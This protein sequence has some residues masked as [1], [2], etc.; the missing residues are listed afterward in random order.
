MG[1]TPREE[2][3]HS[4]WWHNVKDVFLPHSHEGM[5]RTDPAME[6]S[7]RGMRA[8]WA[9]MVLLAV[10]TLV[11]LAVYLVSGSVAL[12]GDTL[13]N[14]ADTLTAVPLAVA[15]TIGRRL[16]TR[17][18]TYG[19]GRA[20]DV[21][22][23]AIVVLIAASAVFAAYEAIDRLTSPETVHHVWAVGVA[24]AV[25]FLGNEFVARYRIKVGRE[26]GS[27][28]LVADGLHARTDGFTSLA[29]VA[30]AIGVALGWGL[31]DPVFGLV[32]TVG[33]GFVLWDAAR[34]VYRRVMDAV[35]PAL[36]SR[37][38]GVLADVPGVLRVGRV[39]MRWVGHALYA[40]ADVVVDG[41]R[42]LAAAHE[43]TADA[44]Q[45]LCAD[46]PRLAGAVIHPDP[47]GRPGHGPV[48]CHPTTE[49]PRIGRQT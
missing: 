13:H 9:S 15:F 1:G 42:T 38:E 41:T 31:A 47:Q 12:L 2:S 3:S 32:V 5:E 45:R 48:W 8:L 11:Q 34:Q 44:E 26:I 6:T 4:G 49:G 20:E 10:T 36:V 19:Y 24:G 37:A 23:L 27:A 35:D 21:A 7:K 22:G 30:G 33:I 40:D 14:A 18:Y 16:P 28:A 43:V 46:I 29:V 39:R 25:G 17:R